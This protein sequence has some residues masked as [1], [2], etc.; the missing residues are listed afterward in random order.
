MSI[1]DEYV[2][3]FKSSEQY[4][5]NV[6]LSI[7]A[8]LT[9]GESDLF[10]TKW[11]DYKRLHPMDATFIFA[12]YYAEQMKT[13][14]NRRKGHNRRGY[15]KALKSPS[16]LKCSKKEITGIW[17]ARQK[18]DELGIPYDFYCAA[19]TK[20]AD[21]FKWK[22][23]P[24]PWQM[25]GQSSKYVGEEWYKTMV[26]YITDA[27]AERTAAEPQFSKDDFYKIE[28]FSKHVYQVRHQLAVLTYIDTL[29]SKHI[30]MYSFIHKDKILIPGMVKAYYREDAPDLLERVARFAA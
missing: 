1:P 10:V 8:K 19:A 21:K 7:D 29:Q 16:L 24:R 13:E 12:H 6:L 3:S 18:A 27:W 2:G 9:H 15:Y 30:A 4:S 17:K 26:Q 5:L 28:N 23:L 22:H 11:W 20:Y 14:M 25:Y